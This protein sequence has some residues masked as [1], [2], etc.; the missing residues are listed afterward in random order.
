M[1][2]LFIEDEATMKNVVSYILT[3]NPMPEEEALFKVKA[4]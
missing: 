4:K 2:T 3:L 1:A